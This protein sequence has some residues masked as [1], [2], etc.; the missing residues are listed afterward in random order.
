MQ[1][2]EDSRLDEIDHVAVNVADIEN[3]VR[4]YLTSFSCTVERQEKT[5]AILRFRNLK[6]VL[7]LPSQQRGHVGYKK[8]DAAS[9]GEI[10]ERTDGIKST[11]V[12]DPTG[13]IVELI[14]EISS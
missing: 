3:S 11:F 7:I 4:W 6:L 8:T 5:F 2:P 13:N 1:Q 14:P 12:A 10:T 9:F